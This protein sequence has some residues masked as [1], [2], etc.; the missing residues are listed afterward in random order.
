MKIELDVVT[1]TKAEYDVEF[2]A[3]LRDGNDYYAFF[4]ENNL[5][6]N[7]RVMDYMIGKGIDYNT[8]YKALGELLNKSAV[9]ITKEEFQNKLVEILTIINGAVDEMRK[10]HKQSEN[11]QV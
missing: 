3:Y 6:R 11:S 7:V 10:A 1:H 2:P 9:K 8:D 5:K 4:D